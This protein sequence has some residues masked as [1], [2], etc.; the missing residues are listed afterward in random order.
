MLISVYVYSAQ[1]CSRQLDDGAVTAAAALTPLPP[2]P[3]LFPPL[4]GILMQHYEH[5]LVEYFLF[6][7]PGHVVRLPSHW[8]MLYFPC[9]TVPF[10]SAQFLFPTLPAVTLNLSSP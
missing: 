1:S 8:A 3:R 4:R 7:A 10:I 2:S 5:L 6:T 9:S